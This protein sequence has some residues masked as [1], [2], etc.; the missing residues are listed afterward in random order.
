MKN[1]KLISVIIPTYNRGKTLKRTIDSVIEQT[2]QNYEIIVVDDGSTDNTEEIVKQY[3]NHRI[4]YVKQTNQ[5]AQV[6]RN[7][8]LSLAKGEYVSFLD[9]DDEWLPDFLKKVVEKFESDN[10]LGCVYC[11]TG[12]KNED[13]E[14][15]LARKDTLEGYIYKEALAQGY[16]TSPTFLVMKKSCF[17]KI[18]MWDTNLK[19]SQDDD[20]CFRLAKDFK[21]ALIPEILAIYNTDGD[22]Q[23]GGCS[24]RVANGWWILWNKY[25]KDVL[26]F[27]GKEVLAKHY[28][29]CA[30][31]FLNAQDK[32]MSLTALIKSFKYKIIKENL[33]FLT[34]LI[35]AT[36]L[37][38]EKDGNRRI[39]TILGFK[40]KYKKKKVQSGE[41]TLFSNIE[42]PENFKGFTFM[43]EYKY[44]DRAIQR[45]VSLVKNEHKDL[46]II[47][48]G[49][50][51]GDT[52]AVIREKENCP[53]LA[54]E[55]DT[56]Y[57]EYLK[58]N[59]QQ[60]K[61]ITIKEVLLGE[62]DE[63][64]NLSFYESNGTACL[65]DGE[66]K[67]EILTLDTVLNEFESFKTSKFLKVDTDGFDNLILKGAKN[68]LKDIKPV[69]FM[70]YFPDALL[71][72]N[73]NGIDVFDYLYSL[74]YR[75]AMM[76]EN[77]GDYMFSFN[78][79]DKDFIMD[80]Q[81]YFLKNKRIPYCDLC[82]FNETDL[83]LYNNVHESEL[84][85]FKKEK[86]ES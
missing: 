33:L 34:K 79:G 42:R 75:K 16:I 37:S 5:G 19:S 38:K 32:K 68:Y 39:M 57:F 12:I 72:Q 18:G 46:S 74:G 8:G 27:C 84:N 14:T 11:L 6:A 51:I 3:N 26:E 76:Y 40:I 44:Y 82:I 65:K 9:S 62:K 29:E 13:N 17:D 35:S 2:Y 70:E 81:N 64:S 78:L 1:N 56:F 22:G 52:I 49:A 47:D 60:Y 10:T 63:I 71:R 24:K 61:N 41:K 67:N 15:I 80:M 58:R 48:I 28:T 30:K 43:Q 36:I 83:D 85:F 4:T 25:E 50:N 54:L 73:D 45:L 86:I 55:G 31:Y 7:Y 66:N 20:I 21:F 59:S 77:F 23:I 53:I 69:I